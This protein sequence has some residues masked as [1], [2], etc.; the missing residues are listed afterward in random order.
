MGGLGGRVAWAKPAVAAA[1]LMVVGLLI[2]SPMQDA[3][4]A[5]ASVKPTGSTGPS[6]QVVPTGDLPA[7]GGAWHQ[8]FVD[9]FTK[10]APLGSWGTNNSQTVVYTGDHGG[11]WVEYP[12]GWPSTYTNGQPGYQPKQVLS[13]HD[14]VLDFYLHN[15]NSLPSGANP[16]PLVT[17]TSQYQTYGRYTARIKS[18]TVPNYHA[19]WLL[20]PVLDKNGGCAESDF[21]ETNLGNDTVTA[22]AHN[23][24]KCKDYSVQK[25]YDS[26]TRIDDGTWH[27]YTQ[28][29]GPGFRKYYLDNTLLGTSTTRVWSQNERWQLQ[30]EPDGAGNTAG[31]LLVDWVAG[32][33]YAPATTAPAPA[34]APA[35]TG[36][37]TDEA[38]KAKEAGSVHPGAICARASALGSTDTGTAMTCSGNP[39]RWRPV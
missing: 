27:T 5:T 22:F 2:A 6:G 25:E 28:E 19:A 31:H 34:P 37:G 15:V 30:T 23:S 12:D 32:Y 35:E 14:G 13:V 24:T 39:P 21:P 3:Q 4:A 1:A 11:K 7:P 18:D 8:T 29:W 16:S 20:W 33:A 38:A 10:D 9:D 36:P 17:G 26:T